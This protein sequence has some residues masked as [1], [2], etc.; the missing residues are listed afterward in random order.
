MKKIL[1][2]EDSHTVG[3]VIRHVV[4]A[5]C[6]FNGLYASSFAETRSIVTEHKADIFAALVD[7]SLPDAPDGEV[8]DYTLSEGI[9]TIVLTGRAD[10]DTREK[11]F[12]K[13]VVDYVNKEGRYSYSY[14][15]NF[16]NRLH[17]NQN[18]KVLIVDDSPSYLKFISGLLRL[19]LFQVYT[20]TDGVEAIKVLVENPE[21]T[22][23]IVDFN[24]PKMDGFELV[25]TLRNKYEKTD[26][27]IIGLS[28][29]GDET[30]SAKF[31]KNGANDFLRK[32]FNQEEFQCRVM[33]NVESL[34][35]IAA[36]RELINRDFLTNAYNRRYF[37][38]NAAGMYEKAKSE[39]TPFAVAVIDIDHFK[40]INDQFGHHN[41]D[42]ALKFVTNIIF[43]SLQRFLFARAGGEEFFIAMPGLTNTQACLL[44]DRLREVVASSPIEMD[45]ELRVITFSAGV[46]NDLSNSLDDQLKIADANLYRAKDAGRNLVI[47]DDDF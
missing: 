12:K 46:S 31:I 2:V 45:G 25:R 27:V 5:S 32:P 39:D 38:Q 11:L 36:I 26:L 9:P 7:L 16:V 6:D 34:E 44:I 41:G 35:Q 30:L 22:L 19:Y 14:A 40:S 20:A 4:N 43:E 24:M 15:V 47:G 8:V 13:G 10:D 28:G 42:S 18:V 33:H 23:M 29:E 3:K 21:I 37:F 1:V 17:R